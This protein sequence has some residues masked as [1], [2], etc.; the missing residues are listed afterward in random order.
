MERDVPRGTLR[1]TSPPD[2]GGALLTS[3]L[4]PSQLVRRGL[5]ELDLAHAELEPL[6]QALGQLAELLAHWSTRMNLAALR[7]AE[8]VC[9]G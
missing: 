3:A 2:L 9:G 8:A 5:E 1:S 4:P 6:A 7:D